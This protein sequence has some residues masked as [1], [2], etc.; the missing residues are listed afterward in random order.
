ML[1]APAARALERLIEPL[2]EGFRAR[3]LPN[4]L[5]SEDLPWWARRA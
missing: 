1:L 2:D 4:P 3:S 5:T